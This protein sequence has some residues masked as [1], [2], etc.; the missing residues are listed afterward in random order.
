MGLRILAWASWVREMNGILR[1][2]N[3]YF[4]KEM[5]RE[6]A[7][8]PSLSGISWTEINARSFS[9]S[10]GLTAAVLYS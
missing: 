9:S 7:G 3:F 5:L 1:R 10:A 6:Y 4:G 2:I 8:L